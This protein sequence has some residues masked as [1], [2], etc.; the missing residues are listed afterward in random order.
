MA[1]VGKIDVQYSKN[2]CKIL[3]QHSKSNSLP[4]SL[5]NEL[6][7]EFNLISENPSINVIVL[8]SIG[9]NT[10][11]A[12]A[13]FEELLAIEN[14]EEGKKFFMGFANLIN[15]MRKCP[16]FIIGRVQG[17]VVGGG[18]GLVAACDYVLASE[19]ASVKLS[20]LALGIGP[21]VI[22]PVV[23]RRIGKAAFQSLTINSEWR[24]PEWA[25]Q[26]GLYDKVLRNVEQLDLEI[27]TLTDRLSS[28]N[29]DA[30]KELKRTFWNDALEWDKLLETN[31]EISGRLVLTGHTKSFINKFK[32]NVKG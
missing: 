8:T 28:S 21:F 10:F 5:L 27:K 20:E 16:K 15:A 25:L 31:A 26:K 30:I 6:T 2:M 3:F 29:P 19:E 11:C 14:I 24:N 17:K 9:E 32:N 1:N 22:Q 13:S 23:E 4:L 7:R 18:V 12:G